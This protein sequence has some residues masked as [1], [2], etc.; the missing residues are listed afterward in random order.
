MEVSAAQ[1]STAGG[2]RRTSRRPAGPLARDTSRQ[3]P[4][5]ALT[6]RTPPM[7]SASTRSC[8]AGSSPS[9]TTATRETSPS[10]GLP[11]CVR[12][13]PVSRPNSP[14]IAACESTPRNT[15]FPL[16][17][18]SM[19]VR[20]TTTRREGKWP[21]GSGRSTHNGRTCG[22]APSA[23][24]V[25]TIFTRSPRNCP[26]VAATQPPST[27]NSLPIPRQHRTR[28]STL[29]SSVNLFPHHRHQQTAHS[30]T[31]PK[32][33]PNDRSPTTP[34]ACSRFHDALPPPPQDARILWQ[35]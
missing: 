13:G 26:L 6:L 31:S 35:R 5:K 21:N 7:P 12:A 33:P 17:P 4:T 23:L 24:K 30:L 22:A 9:S 18:S 27:S 11:A 25:T 28:P 16:P 19:P 15:T 8:N 32:F 34:P 20:P 1:S 2:P 10:R 29:K 3:R 14:P